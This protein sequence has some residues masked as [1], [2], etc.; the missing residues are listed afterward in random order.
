MVLHMHG[1][2]V[3]DSTMVLYLVVEYSNYTRVP[4]RVSTSFAP[5]RFP[6]RVIWVRL[7]GPSAVSYMV[8]MVPESDSTRVPDSTRGSMS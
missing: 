1:M 4:N 8:M 7:A 2:H 3:R 5:S 6:C